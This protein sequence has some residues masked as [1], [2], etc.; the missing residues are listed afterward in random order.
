MTQDSKESMFNA[1]DLGSIPGSGRSP[2]GVHGNPL[3]YFCLENPTDRGTWWA[4]DHGVTKSWTQLCDFLK[5][6]QHGEDHTQV[7]YWLLPLGVQIQIL[8]KENN[9]VTFP[10]TVF[11]STLQCKLI[12]KN[13]PWEGGPQ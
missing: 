2:G 4:T 3:Q 8:L 6:R 1:R 13:S 9:L 7:Y 5:R 12:T 10:T 11:S